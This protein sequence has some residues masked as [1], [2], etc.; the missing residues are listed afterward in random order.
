MASKQQT[1]I[2]TWFFC[3]TYLYWFWTWYITV[4]KMDGLH[5]SS[6]LQ[7]IL[8]PS[9]LPTH[10]LQAICVDKTNN[11]SLQNNNNN[12]N[13]LLI[14]VYTYIHMPAY[15]LRGRNVLI[16][17]SV[18]NESHILWKIW[19]FSLIVYVSLLTVMQEESSFIQ[20]FKDGQ[21]TFPMAYRDFFVD[22]AGN[23]VDFS[24][25]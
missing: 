10:E 14:Y 11:D 8:P 9:H 7:N 5:H 25:F 16:P 18:R 17:K 4:S 6:L 12:E 3:I 15:L 21:Q 19:H 13:K 20:R 23:C 2:C 1:A 22:D 24:F